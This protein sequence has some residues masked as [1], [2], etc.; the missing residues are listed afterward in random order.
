MKRSLLALVLAPLALAP[1][2]AFGQEEGPNTARDPL[3][4]DLIERAAAKERLG[5]LEQAVKLYLELE[6]ALEKRRAKDKNDRPTTEVGPGT[7]RG[8]GLYLRE[9]VARLPAA[10]QESYRLTIDPR[11]KREFE[12]AIA[13]G[14]PERI[15][16]AIAHYP[17]ASASG[18]ALEALANRALERGE[19]G[20]AIRA[21]RR[22]EAREGGE[23]EAR[24][25]IARRAALRRALVALI[26]GDGLEAR[27]AAKSFQALG[28]DPARK[29]EG[30]GKSLAERIALL[31]AEGQA[32]G[33]ARGFDPGGIARTIPLPLPELPDALAERLDPPPAYQEPVVLGDRLLVADSKTVRALGLKPL[34]RGW[35]YCSA[36]ADSQVS[37]LEAL[38]WRPASGAGRV[39]ATFHRNRP[40]KL[41]AAAAQP[42]NQP[43][44]PKN[45]A[46]PEDPPVIERRRDWRVVAL[47]ASSGELLWDAGDRADFEEVA[48]ESEWV[49]PPLFHE[50]AVYVATLRRKTD[51][52][53]SLLRLDPTDGSVVYHVFLASR[54]AYDYLGIASP[55][56]APSADAQGR[57]V[58]AT[59]IGAVAAVDP[60]SGDLAW[61]AR[62]PT[63]PQESQGPIID[64]GRRFFAASPLAEREPLVVAPV[65]GGELVAFG[66]AGEARWSAPR[67]EARYVVERGERLYLVGRRLIV[68]DRADGRLLLRGPELEAPCCAKPLLLGEELVVS[69]AQGLLC[70]GLKDGEVRA[71]WR[72]ARPTAECGAPVLGPDG[73]LAVCGYDGLHV[74]RAL[75]DAERALADLEPGER[76]LQRGLLHARRGDAR[77]ALPLLEAAVRS[78]LTRTRALEAQVAGLELMAAE[79]RA[80]GARDDFNGFRIAAEHALAFLGPLGLREERVLG[81]AQLDLLQ[82][83]APLLVVYA[84]ELAARPEPEL[85]AKAARAFQR[86]LST[87]P[88]TRVHLGGEA[89][90]EASDYA[91]ARLLELVRARGADVYAEES[92]QAQRTLELAES[93]RDQRGM[94]QVIERWP[95]S[96]AARQ[97]RWALGELLAAQG[98]ARLAAAQFE[99]FVREHP[100][101]ERVPEALA[102]LARA[103]QATQRLGEAR[104]AL[105]RLRALE[106]E[107][108]VSGGPEG[109]RQPARAWAAPLREQLLKGQTPESLARE[110][111]RRGLDLPLVEVYRGSTQLEMHGPELVEVDAPAGLGG[112]FVLRED[113]TLSVLRAPEGGLLLRVPD[114]PRTIGL[115]PCL[116]GDSLVVPRPDRVEVYELGGPE[117]RRAWFSDF[118]RGPGARVGA[119]PVHRVTV[120]KDLVLVLRGNNALVAYDLRSGRPRWS[121]VLPAI[122]GG[123]I[124]VRGGHALAVSVSPPLVAGISLED[125]AVRWTYSPSPAPGRS[126]LIASPTP[127]GA[128]RL[129]FIYGGR[130]VIVLDAER[131]A[132]AWRAAAGGEPFLSD[133]VASGDAL[134]VRHQAGAGLGVVVL[135]AKTGKE[136]WR[137]EGQGPVINGQAPP[138]GVPTVIPERAGVFLGEDA[139]YTVRE[140]NGRTELW[141]QDLAVGTTRWRWTLQ[142]G[143][144]VF[145]VIETPTAVLVPNS[146][147]I[148]SRLQL[149]VLELGSGRLKNSFHLSGRQLIGA[150]AVVSGGA[151]VLSGEKAVFAF[152]RGDE[153]QLAREAV[154]LARAVAKAPG[155]AAA[156]AR[157]ATRLAR[158]G[159]YEEALALLQAGVLEEGLTVPDFDRLFALLSMLN[160][161]QAERAPPTL[162]LRRLPRPPEIDGELNDWWR[163]WSA[164]EMRGPRHVIPVQQR[165]GEAPGRWTGREDLSAKLYLGYDQTYFYFALDVEDLNLR[166]YDSEAERWIGDCLLIAIDCK[167][168]GGDGARGDDVLL[169]LA[170]TL[171]K[172]KDEK[173]DDEQQQ[174]E[175]QK[176]KPEGRYF[177]HRK[178]DKSGAV[179]EVAIPWSLL[180]KNGADLN[181]LTGPGK[182]LTF[183]LNVI[184]TDDDGDR[185]AVTDPDDTAQD[186]GA[187]G[188]LKALELTPG[189]LL[190]HDKSRLWKGFIPKRFA[191][192]RIE[193]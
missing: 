10:A 165:P 192:V 25:A 123:G 89:R 56:P 49:S 58:V 168:D 114:V 43:A 5:D 85:W 41:V 28:G 149:D 125:G 34:V 152:A 32:L 137:D 183:G 142:I 14:E 17:L 57:V 139:L 161:Q 167:S 93:A 79:A 50:G 87:P 75:D 182:G 166:P 174:E 72:W 29:A 98:L 170:L 129:G 12:D 132:E 138:P 150:Q 76:E 121:R 177:V 109:A 51:L 103:Y 116:L 157:L 71:R 187:R 88:G 99:A 184:L 1:V 69:T 173:S 81:R 86:L 27:D 37:R 16:A 7:D 190:H 136:R 74:Y 100:Q 21:Y 117:P 19:L 67:G 171:P 39:F 148:A 94:L 112:R 127:V 24:R 63:V 120:A 186:K 141:S 122:A 13:T 54:S 30:G 143:A 65:D 45:P 64:A 133:L 145:S 53:A 82:R 160:E 189:V 18:A 95:A 180:A 104:D 146:G 60:S 154:E 61:V 147:M 62:Y 96:A 91:R 20:R 101:D 108:Q 3:L 151:L 128:D 156:R 169:S 8:V 113:E 172:K 158:Q 110:K 153:E 162:T 130:D 176:K 144:G 70:V 78:G 4:D 178:E 97:A 23:D 36:D 46:K 131:G 68:L 11:A 77:R 6:M 140:G 84:D 119:N 111:D 22:I 80:R 66:P 159:R 134:V 35:S 73:S 9:R 105:E 179:Y 118:T 181:P 115:D 33:V 42:K 126:Q 175:E 59:G 135:D 26:R 92:R 47:D 188:A 90:V 193:E 155:D 102:R 48:R 163:G 55:L 15:E 38:A 40:A 191:K 83:A 44:Q 52:R 2:M 164:V 107:P 106:P 124:I 185:A 31:P